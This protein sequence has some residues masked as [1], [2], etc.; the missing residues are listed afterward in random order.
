VLRIIDLANVGSVLAIQTADVA[1]RT[2]DG[3]LLIGRD[4]AAFREDVRARRMR[5]L[6]S[7]QGAN[8]PTR[9]VNQHLDHL[10]LC[11]AAVARNHT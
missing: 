2:E 8:P 11:P 6:R 3:F 10:L 9:S 4:P 5:R 7:V 1:V